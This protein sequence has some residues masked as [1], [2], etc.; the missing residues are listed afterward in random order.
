MLNTSNTARWFIASQD[1]EISTKLVI[2]S[3]NS[4]ATFEY[5]PSFLVFAV[6]IHL[7]KKLN[8]SY[9]HYEDQIFV[10]GNDVSFL[11]SKLVIPNSRLPNSSGSSEVSLFF[12][13]Y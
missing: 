12:E 11:L 7:S 9:T 3:Y 2:H 6:A 1:L 8:Q 13:A 4:R 5:L 10:R